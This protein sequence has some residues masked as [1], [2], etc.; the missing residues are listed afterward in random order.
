LLDNKINTAGNEL[1]PTMQGDTLYYSSDGFAG[2]GGLDIYK[3]YP[4][5]AGWKTPTN[6]GYPVNSS[7]DDFGIIFNQTKQKVFLAATAS[8]QMIF[9]FLKIP[10][11]ITMQGT[12][13]SKP[14]CAGLICN[15]DTRR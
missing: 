10:F 8:A 12:V 14:P 2:L 6:M 5:R 15:S 7:F 11:T 9:M 3:T 4:T 13:L 1:F